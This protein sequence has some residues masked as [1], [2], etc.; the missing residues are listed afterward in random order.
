MLE[1]IMFKK[2]DEYTENEIFNIDTGYQKSRS[3]VS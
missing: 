2:N 3:K 1:K